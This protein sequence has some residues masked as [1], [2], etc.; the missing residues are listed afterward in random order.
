[1]DGFSSHTFSFISPR[2][3]RYWVKFHLKTE[4]GIQNLS[5]REA[6][7][8][9]GTNP[10]HATQDLF[11]AI[12]REDYPRWRLSVQIM[13]EQAAASYH[14]NPF[15]LTKVWPH[16]DYPLIPVGE[17]ELNRNPENYFAEIEQ[18]SFAPANVVP[19]ISFSPDKMLQAAYSRTPTLTGTGSASTTSRCR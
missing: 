10:D 12:S 17:L 1:M 9:A 16:R 2:N 13:P 18:A 15:D 14:L 6:V 5:S 8:L 11:E 7:E 19:G 3:E 4:Q